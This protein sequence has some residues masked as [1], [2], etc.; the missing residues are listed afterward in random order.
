MQQHVLLNHWMLYIFSPRCFIIPQMKIK[1]C[2][3][4]FLKYYTG[5]K[6]R[7]KMLYLAAINER[8]KFLMTRGYGKSF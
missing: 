4:H 3:Q 6:L 8:I 7:P 1:S 2:F 5:G